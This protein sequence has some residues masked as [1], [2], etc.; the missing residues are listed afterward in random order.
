MNFYCNC[1]LSRFKCR[2]V[3]LCLVNNLSYSLWSSLHWICNLL[4]LLHFFFLWERDLWRRNNHFFDILRLILA[5]MQIKMDVLVYIVRKIWCRVRVGLISPPPFH[6]SSKKN[7]VA[8]KTMVY[9]SC[10]VMLLFVKGGVS[11]FCVFSKEW[12]LFVSTC[13][14]TIWTWRNVLH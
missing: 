1:L 11:F 3:L 6:S 4:P 7:E 10:S 2:Q 8:M 13:T 14:S 12:V 9:Q 5:W